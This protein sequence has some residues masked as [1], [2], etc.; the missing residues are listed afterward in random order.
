MMIIKDC[1]VSSY[2]GNADVGYSED[3]FVIDNRHRRTSL[4]LEKEKIVY[5]F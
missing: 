3:N 1:D 5:L 2:L 4:E